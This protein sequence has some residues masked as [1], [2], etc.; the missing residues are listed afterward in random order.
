MTTDNL[1]QLAVV[2]SLAENFVITLDA[3]GNRWIACNGVLLDYNL[4]CTFM[5]WHLGGR[6]KYYNSI[7][8]LRTNHIDQLLFI[9]KHSTYLSDTSTQHVIDKLWVKFIDCVAKMDKDTL[10]AEFNTMLTSV[11]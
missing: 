5:I 7:L 10:A 1:Y 3:E 4:F 6:Y 9:N 8:Q 2:S 11:T